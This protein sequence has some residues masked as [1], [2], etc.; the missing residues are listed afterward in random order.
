MIARLPETSITEAA[1][2]LRALGVE[3]G[4]TLLLHVSFRAVRPIENGPL[5][6]IAA[7]RAALGSEG[8]LVMPSWTGD[9]DRVFDP[10]TTACDPHLG[11][12]ADLFWRQ[13]GVRRSQHPFAFAALGAK[14]EEIVRG[15][16]VLPPHGPEGPLG[17]LH[18][19]AA[20]I[21][22]LGV[23]QDANTSI[24]L[25]ELLAGV[26]YRRAKHVT[27]MGKTGPER[28]DYGE[29]DHC[30]ARFTLADG[31]LWDKG[32]LS[33]GPVASAA[34]K[35]MR[36]EDLVATLVPRLEAEPLIFLHPPGAGCDECDDARRSLALSH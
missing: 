17:R 8:T 32:L 3:A 25:C 10:T 19:A 36:I 13:P 33:E 4:D 9:D 28:I 22:L 14:A 27:V 31:W 21:L 16:M 29:N 18:N 15:P 11:I 24:H 35:L 6:L 20:R 26:P 2:Q 5:G 34:A 7:L 23:G 30:C 12:V 1:A